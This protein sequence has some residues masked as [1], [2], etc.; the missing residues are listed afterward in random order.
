MPPP[1]SKRG[2]VLISPV[3]TLSKLTRSSKAPSSNPGK[4]ALSL[5]PIG[6]FLV[7]MPNELRPTNSPRNS[8]YESRTFPHSMS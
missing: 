2:E 4:P 6:Q 7:H 3:R 1:F 8:A 5:G